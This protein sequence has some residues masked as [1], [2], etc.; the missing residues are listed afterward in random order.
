MVLAAGDHLRGEAAAAVALLVYSDFQCPA[1]QGQENLLNQV[2]DEYG[3]RLVYAFRNFPLESLHKNAK[4]AAQAAEAADLQSSFWAY[5]D[6]LFDRQS[7]WSSLSDPR[8]KF[9][10]YA[11]ELGLDAEKLATD[12]AS[13]EVKNLV[14]SDIASGN[15]LGLSWTPSIFI[16]GTLVKK[17]PQNVNGL[18]KLIDDALPAVNN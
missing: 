11:A 2:T 17:N 18:K 9:K 4:A 16:N 1:C 8:D 7:E 6:L 13:D 15:K 14:E 12:S 5:H 3:D 10:D